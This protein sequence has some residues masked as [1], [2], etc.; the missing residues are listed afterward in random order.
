M[1]NLN[2]Q[3]ST[4]MDAWFW[5]PI[6]LFAKNLSLKAWYYLL[7]SFVDDYSWLWVCCVLQLAAPLHSEAELQHAIA[8][9]G[10]N[11]FLSMFDLLLQHGPRS[12]NYTSNTTFKPRK[13]K[14][15][16]WSLFHPCVNTIDRRPFWWSRMEASYCTFGFGAIIW[17]DLH[18][19]S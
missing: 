16:I 1:Q 6:K 12:E 8:Y 13:L 2:P 3:P 17:H 14:R 18:I 9:F 5:I 10:S 15:G 19:L 11:E 4:Y 7:F